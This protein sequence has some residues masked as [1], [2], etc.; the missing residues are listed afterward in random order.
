MVSSTPTDTNNDNSNSDTMPTLLR[1]TRCQG[2]TRWGRLR[3]QHAA[4][5]TVASSKKIIASVQR[6]TGMLL[7][8]ASNTE[9]HS[10]QTQCNA[11]R[12][13]ACRT[14]PIQSGFIGWLITNRKHL[15]KSAHCNFTLGSTMVY[16]ISVSTKPAIYNI[17]PRNTMARTT[18]KSCA[19]I[20]SIV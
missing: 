16:E 4:A 15:R 13:T 8:P 18:P 6:I 2:R 14:Y 20:A 19:L 7:T 17:E 12:K 1:D 9:H 5:T 11:G 10:F 3:I